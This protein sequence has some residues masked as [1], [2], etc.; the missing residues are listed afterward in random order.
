[1]EEFG[2]I[3]ALPAALRGYNRYYM[4]KEQRYRVKFYITIKTHIIDFT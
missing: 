4:N 1:M 2:K 3:L